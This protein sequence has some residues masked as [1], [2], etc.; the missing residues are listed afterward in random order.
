MSFRV[1]GG[2]ADAEYIISKWNDTLIPSGKEPTQTMEQRIE[3]CYD[4][5]PFMGV[6][7]MSR[8][9]AEGTAADVAA[10]AETA[11]PFAF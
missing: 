8:S 7:S 11:G 4:S 2:I 5:T 1:G 10:P 3:K 9:F 6:S